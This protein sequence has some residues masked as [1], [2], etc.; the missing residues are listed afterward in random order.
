M[1]LELDPNF[2]MLRVNPSKAMGFK[3]VKN[4]L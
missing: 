1:H 4:S 2:D 3:L